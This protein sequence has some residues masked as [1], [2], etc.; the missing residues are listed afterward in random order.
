MII[1]E[2]QTG[3]GRTGHFLA[4]E[5]EGLSYDILGLGKVTCPLISV[6]EIC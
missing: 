1:D 6:Q 3:N 2:I 5:Q 4:S